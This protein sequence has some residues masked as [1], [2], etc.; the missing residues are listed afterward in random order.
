VEQE[1]IELENECA[2]AWVKSDAAFYERMSVVSIDGRT[3]G[4]SVLDVGS[5]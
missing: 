2:D 3:H 5:A 1:L 4:S